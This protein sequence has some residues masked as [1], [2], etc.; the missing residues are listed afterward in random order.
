MATGTLG[1]QARLQPRQVVNTWRKQ[2]NYNDAGIG[3]GV[4]GVVL[5]IGAFILRV[6]VEIVTAFNAATTNVLTVGTNSATYNDIVAAGDVD[7]ATAGVYDVTRG[8]GRSLTAAADTTVY[9][10]YTQTGDAATAGQAEIVIEYEGN[11]G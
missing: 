10:M 5:P 11:T 7:E 3:S 1:D 6:L 2:V 8:L 9:V 4:A